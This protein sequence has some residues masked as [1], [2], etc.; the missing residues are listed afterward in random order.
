M[1]ARKRISINAALFVGLVIFFLVGGRCA[2]LS[3]SLKELE[4]LCG[5]R[6]VTELYSSFGKPDEIFEGE[7][8]QGRGWEIPHWPVN[9]KVEVFI[10]KTGR[11]Y[12]VY[13]DG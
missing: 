13:V 5:A 10:G 3:K 2:Y 4:L 11:K 9:G 1:A 7:P 8:I 12:F 6:N